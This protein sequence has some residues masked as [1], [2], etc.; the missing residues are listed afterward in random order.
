MRYEVKINIKHNKN[1]FRL[2]YYLKPHR[3]AGQGSIDTE[4]W[5]LTERKVAT[6]SAAKTPRLLHGV[7]SNGPTGLGLGI[8]HWSC[9][10]FALWSFWSSG[11]RSLVRD[12]NPRGR[13]QL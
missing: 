12:M 4:M 9:D 13:L 3:R 1:G 7:I 6:H 5:I 8:I 11:V 2:T 10:A